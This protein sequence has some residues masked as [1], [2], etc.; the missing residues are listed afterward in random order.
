MSV[1]ALTISQTGCRICCSSWQS[2]VVTEST[3]AHQSREKSQALF[4]TNR[5]TDTLSWCS[6]LCRWGRNRE[7]PEWQGTRH[8]H[9]S[10]CKTVP[11]RVLVFFTHPCWCW[12]V[13][14]SV[15]N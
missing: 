10:L 5:F 4:T 13:L 8:T 14:S 11:I 15:C 12:C 7:H 1:R 2:L 6:P 3:P 9:S